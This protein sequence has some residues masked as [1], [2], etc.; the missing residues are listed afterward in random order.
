M[1]AVLRAGGAVVPLGV[2]LTSARVQTLVQD[3][4][5][6]VVL[7]DIAQ[8]ERFNA[9]VSQPIL[10]TA[11]LFDSLPAPRITISRANPVNPAWAIFTSGSTGVPKGVVLEHQALCSGILASGVRYGVSSSTRNFQSL[12]SPSMLVL[13]TF[14]PL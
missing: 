11:S 9:L 1:L 12:P 8:A 3:S 4:K 13:P 6:S 2:Q 10:V 14:L 5:I 7:V